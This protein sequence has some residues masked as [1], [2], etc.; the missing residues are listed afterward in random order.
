M[1]AIETKYRATRI[2]MWFLTGILLLAGYYYRSAALVAFACGYWIVSR[3][4]WRYRAIINVGIVFHLV[5]TGLTIAG[6]F[7]DVASVSWLDIF[8][9]PI[10]VAFLIIYYPSPY[11]VSSNVLGFLCPADWM[12][13]WMDAHPGAFIKLS[14]RGIIG[15][16]EGLYANSDAFNVLQEEG[17]LGF[18]PARYIID[19]ARKAEVRNGETLLDIGCGTGGPACTLAAEFGLTVTGVDLLPWNVERSRALA[20]ARRL[21]GVCRF[22]QADALSLPFDD[23]TFDYVFGSDAW[24]HVPERE[25]LLREAHRVLK[26][27]GT[28]FFHDWIQYRGDSECFRFIYAFP[29]LETMDSYREKL[30]QAG[31][32]IITAEMRNDAFREH[33]TDLRATL[34]SRKRLMIDTCGRELYD[35]WDIVSRYTLK[36]IEEEKLGSGLF[37]AEKK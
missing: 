14:G 3:S 20:A 31:F 33:V 9:H 11:P 16:V 10:T 22:Q 34:R 25:K 4:P 21:D 12:V 28:I 6:L 27:G 1:N 15:T 2:L 26:P 13:S 23:N 5:Q 19:T 18:S 17:F 36:M 29:H 8:L 32:E 7:A 24:C 37:I 35:N 30:G